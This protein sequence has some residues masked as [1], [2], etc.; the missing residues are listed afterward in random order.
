[1]KVR[2]LALAVVAGL[3]VVLPGCRVKDSGGN[4]S[5][6]KQLF[7]AKCGSCHVLQRAG[8]KGVTGPDLDAAFAQDRRD[9]IPSDSIRGLVHKQI[10]YPARGGVM[11]GK[12]VTGDDAYDVATYVAEAASKTGKDTGPLAAIGGAAKKTNAV[13][14]NGKVAIPADPTGQL[15]YLVAN[16]TAPAG[17]LEIDSPNKSSTPHNI[18]VQGPGVDEKGPVIDNGA[19]STIR[20]DLKPGL[21]T[22]YCSVDGHRQAGMI[23]KL[24]VK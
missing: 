11:P 17:A 7:I 22:F 18:A 3:L 4:A 20:L 16:A 15:A 13:A 19:V 14:K 24:T 23:G 9:G 1:M 12:L 6:G 8:S 21:Y 10:L 5:N 2:T